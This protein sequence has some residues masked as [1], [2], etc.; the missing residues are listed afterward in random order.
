MIKVHVQVW[1]T[2]P[3]RTFRLWVNCTWCSS[4]VYIDHRKYRW[5][6]IL[7][8]RH[9][10]KHQLLPG[11]DPADITAVTAR[12]KSKVYAWTKYVSWKQ[13]LYQEG[14][15]HSEEVEKQVGK[16]YIS[17]TPATRASCQAIKPAWGVTHGQG[18]AVQLCF[19]STS[20]SSI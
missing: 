8:S 4:A 9:G 7:E 19:P 5:T 11:T 15:H 20:F 13:Y 10:G 2:K 18:A 16:L 14:N 17:F 6:D 3:G 12:T 1:S